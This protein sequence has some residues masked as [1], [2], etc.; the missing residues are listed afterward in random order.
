SPDDVSKEMRSRAKTA[1]FGIIYGIS[2]FGLAQRL[3]I[4]RREAK[5]LIDGYFKSYPGVKTYMDMSIQSAR[6]SGYVKTL[7][8]RRRY[9]PDIQSQNPM[10]RGNAERNAINAPVQGSAADLIKLAMIRI[11][12]ELLSSGLKSRMILQVHDELNFD[13]Y[14]PEISKV[15]DIVRH[16]MEH[17]IQLQV[18]LIV[19]IGTGTSWFEAH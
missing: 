18:P 16:E 4:S 5:S 13:V 2:S 6:D 3:N 1:N 15:R 9:L 10:V 19:D 12:Q 14:K 7:M 17:V 8:G 11:H